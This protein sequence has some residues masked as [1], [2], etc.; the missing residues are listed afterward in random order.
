MVA[1][2]DGQNTDNRVQ[3]KHRTK[4]RQISGV[5]PDFLP[6]FLEYSSLYF[7]NLGQFIVINFALFLTIKPKFS[8]QKSK[9]F[10]NFLGEI[11]TELHHC[12]AVIVAEVILRQSKFSAIISKIVQ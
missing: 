7:N 1:K 3:R 11:L 6:C 4:I 12:F 5:C 9:I 2:T 8:E 10:W